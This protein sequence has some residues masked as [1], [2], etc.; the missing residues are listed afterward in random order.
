[1]LETSLIHDLRT[2]S[3]QQQKILCGLELIKEE[4]KPSCPG[5][6]PLFGKK[7]KKKNVTQSIICIVQ[8]CLLKP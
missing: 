6:P 8:H 2:I 1:M 5:Y 3:V 7:K 4:K